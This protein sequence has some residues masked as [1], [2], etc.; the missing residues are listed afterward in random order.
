MRRIAVENLKPGMIVAQDVMPPRVQG[1]PYVRMG[2]MLTVAMIQEMRRLGIRFAFIQDRADQPFSP[3]V[4]STKSRHTPPPVRTQPPPVNNTLRTNAV[5]TLKD[6]FTTVET[7]MQIGTKDIHDAAQVV[8]RLDAVVD[9]LI[10]S[11]SSHS[12]MTV[13]INNLKSYD[14]YTYHHSLSVAVLALA[15]GQ[16][17]GLSQ[18]QLKQLGM[19]AM[20]HDIGKT[21]VPL[22]I[23]HKPSR[24]SDS[25]FHIIKNHSPAG[26][27]YLRNA[28]IVDEDVLRG[29][30]HHHEKFDGTGYPSNIK[31]EDIPLY[32]RILAV[33]DVY[34]ALTSNRPYRQPNQ[35]AEAVEY[36]MGGVGSAFDYD[37]VTAFIDRLELYP[38]GSRLRL[39]N[40]FTVTVLSNEHQL[41]P[42]VRLDS[43]EILD[44]YRDASCRSIVIIGFVTV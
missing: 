33:A 32:S 4:S 16:Q 12:R 37:I 23:L 3:S 17:M 39:S 44:L 27:D 9:Q 14:E 8:K 20:M 30:L 38:V 22:E 34:D 43:G 35:P 19:C 31:G 40:G 36:V 6:L 18:M 26:Y 13:N 11:I 15:T 29:V 42:V 41:R 1:T 24:L 7:T 2:T 25:E 5:D 10:D 28:N 21:T